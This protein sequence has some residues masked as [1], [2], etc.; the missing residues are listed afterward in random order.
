MSFE[1]LPHRN[2]RVVLLDEDIEKYPRKEEDRLTPDELKSIA[3]ML[4]ESKDELSI[5]AQVSPIAASS[6]DV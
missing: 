5:E 2:T 6:S 1:P 3:S 4:D